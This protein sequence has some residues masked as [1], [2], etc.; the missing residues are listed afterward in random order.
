MAS[1]KKLNAHIVAKHHRRKMVDSCVECRLLQE[2][3]QWCFS[4]HVGADLV[5]GRLLKFRNDLK[6]MRWRPVR[7][8]VAGMRTSDDD[9]VSVS[10]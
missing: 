9:S 3:D 10:S 8:M 4:R 7:S 2:E 6:W 5:K 1:S